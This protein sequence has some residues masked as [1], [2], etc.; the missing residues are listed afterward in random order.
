MTTSKGY[1][2]KLGELTPF[3]RGMKKLLTFNKKKYATFI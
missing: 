3:S 2:K 1:K